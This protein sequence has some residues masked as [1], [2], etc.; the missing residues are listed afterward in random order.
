MDVLKYLKENNGIIFTEQQEKVINHVDGPLLTIAVPGA[1]KTTALITRT[2]N[3]IFAHGIPANSILTLTFSRPSAND[4]KDRFNSLFGDL[5]RKNNISVKFS[6][7][8]S[9]AYGLVRENYRFKELIETK[10]ASIHKSTIIKSIYKDL[11][12]DFIKDDIYEQLNTSISYIK[13]KMLDINV[14]SKDEIASI[15]DIKEFK[16]IFIQ[17]EEYKK[18]KSFIDFDDMLSI[19]YKLMINDDKILEKY[20]NKYQYIQLDEAQD[21]STIQFAIVELLAK[22]KDNIFYLG[23]TNQSILSF[24]ASD[25][26]HLL[27]FGKIY[28]DGT[29]YFMQKNFRSTKEIIDLS[30]KFIKTNKERYDNDMVTDKEDGRPVSIIYV[31]NEIKEIEYIIGKIKE[32]NN[33]KESVILYRNNITSV[34]L[35]D[36][37][38]KEG[39]GFY[40]RDK[41]NGFFNNWVVS[42]ILSFIKLSLDKHDYD[43][44]SNIYYKANLY[45]NKSTLYDSIKYNNGQGFIEALLS[46]SYLNDYQR[47]NINMF[48]KDLQRLRKAKGKQI[49]K[50][51]FDDIRYKEYLEKNAKNMGYSFES[52]F[53]ILNIFSLITKDC[54]SIQDVFTHFDHIKNLLRTAEDNK[55]SDVVTLSSMHGSKGLEW[56]NVYLMNMVEGVFPSFQATS[57]ALKGDNSLMEEE[58]RLC[59]VALTRGR[60]Y[61]DITVSKTKNGSFVYP[62]IFIREIESISKGLDKPYVFTK[63]TASQ[64]TL[65]DFLEDFAVGDEVLHKIFGSGVI[66]DID[67]EKDTVMVDFN[68]KGVKKLLYSMCR[69]GIL[70]KA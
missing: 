44:L 56:D 16:D 68:I 1:G 18:K 24:R 29:V 28:P 34:L 62:S 20:R 54:D 36:I 69:S 49:A 51:I 25:M 31:D 32:K 70:S 46:L 61:V 67:E 64:Q 7:I 12:N 21:T 3:L 66:R 48:N 63:N 19:C 43:S 30:N 52:L 60:E 35:A 38:D 10:D 22:P 13:N 55:G 58:R 4:M 65:N 33:F 8:H 59:Y 26:Q 41:D 57:K 11:A 2:A 53:G 17:Y 23:D 5:A 27:N 50:I 6:T 37:M 14:L 42:D 40:V 15:C 45:I 39:I 9:F 47:Q